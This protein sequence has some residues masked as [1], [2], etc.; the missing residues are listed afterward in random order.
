MRKTERT[1]DDGTAARQRW[2]RGGLGSGEAPPRRAREAAEKPAKAG[3]PAKR[4]VEP[5][6]YS[7]EQRAAIAA[8]IAAEGIGDEM[9]QDIF[10]GAIA[11][12]LAALKANCEPPPADQPAEEPTDATAAAPADQAPAEPA[13]GPAAAQPASAAAPAAAAPAPAPPA[14]AALAASAR[15]LAAALSALDATQRAALAEALGEADRFARTHDD[16]YLEAVAR[17]LEAIAGAVDALTAAAPPGVAEPPAAPAGDALPAEPPAPAIVE[18]PEADRAAAGATAFI[19]HAASVWEQCFD[20]PPAAETSGAFARVLGTIA[21]TTGVPIP[22]D[23]AA[24][25]AALGKG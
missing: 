3:P 23:A 13:A 2:L 24:L 8:A 10:I 17:E 18:I 11:Y 22:T 7:D 20:A 15:A 14:D 12:D 9:A 4:F 19:R 1:R 5:Y 25:D 6:P 16:A 21:E